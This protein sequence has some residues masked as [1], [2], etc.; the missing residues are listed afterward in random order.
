MLSDY[1]VKDIKYTCTEEGD[2]FCKKAQLNLTLQ[3]N[4]TVNVDNFD[5]K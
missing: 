5:W 1:K 2:G 3:D 4:K